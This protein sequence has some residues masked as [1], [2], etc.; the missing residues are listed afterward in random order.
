[1]ALATDLILEADVRYLHTEGA[2][3]LQIE[4]NTYQCPLPCHRLKTT[5]HKA[6]EAHHLF[7]NPEYRQKL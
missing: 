6:A 4:G 1:M 3:T 5:Q 7:N 2:K